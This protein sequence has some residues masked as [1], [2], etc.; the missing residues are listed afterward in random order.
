MRT[1]VIVGGAA[2]IAGIAVGALWSCGT[3][4]V[5]MAELLAA[6]EAEDNLDDRHAEIPF[7]DAAEWV[8]VYRPDDAWNG[9]N[10]V[11]YRRRVPM[12]LDMNG[13]VVHVWP[14]VRALGRIRLDRRGRLTVIGTD[15]I[16]KEYDWNGKLTWAHRM[17]ND[18]HLPHHDFIR[19]ENGNYMVL[20]R[21]K[22]GRIDYLHEVDRK[23]KVVWEWTADDR[24]IDAFP[25]ADLVED[26][27]VHLNS[28]NELPPNRW[29]DGGDR[30]FRPGNILV[31]ARNLDGILVI[32]RKTREVV[33]TYDQGLDYQ[34][35]AA[36]IPKGQLGEGLVIL[37]D[38]GY[39]NRFAYRRSRIV[40]VDPVAKQEVWSYQA[41]GFFSSVGGSQQALPNGN[42]FIT[43]S[44]GG[45]VFEITPGGRVVW[46]WIPPFEPMRAARIAY[47]YCPQ[48][49]ALPRPETTPVD[50]ADRPAWIDLELH[51][52]TLPEEHRARELF[53]ERRELLAGSSGC[54]EFWM[55]PEPVLE[56]GYGFNPE[57]AGNSQLR[58]RF[59][60]SLRGEGESMVRLLDDQWV[61]SREEKPWRDVK[62]ALDG[63]DDR[64]AEVC[65]HVKSE[66]PVGEHDIAS[67]TLWE[68][69]TVY[70]EARRQLHR[71]WL[72]QRQ[73]RQ[74]KT[75]EERQLEA[76]GYVQ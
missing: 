41:P 34:H 2:V 8:E 27:P 45:R 25:N 58:A 40:A 63:Y 11:L 14:R 31:S 42:V 51:Q 75:L 49:A 39:R 74:E 24:V 46:Q 23:G 71:D 3:R 30:R 68:N 73:S 22:T 65:I 67:V 4:D 43:S 12:I 50:R 69:P 62:V 28:V 20:G 57:K 36:M 16:V 70:S 10:L 33:W 47:D 26:D 38:N 48:L 55:P 56:F 35:E 52:F 53:G 64:R 72:D 29:F 5:S 15:D 1:A 60:V 37:F 18:D 66:D 21:V 54:R 7:A 61:D 76:I 59:T 6:V 19:L 9:Y 17:A 44:H 32:D 13:N